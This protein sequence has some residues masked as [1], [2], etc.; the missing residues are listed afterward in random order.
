MVAL[1]GDPDGRGDGEED[2]GPGQKHTKNE[3]VGSNNDL[4]DSHTVFYPGI[5]FIFSTCTAAYKN[6]VTLA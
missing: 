6:R 2:Q 4:V 1:P 5:Q 3:E